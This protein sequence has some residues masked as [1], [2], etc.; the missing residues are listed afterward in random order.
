LRSL[1]FTFAVHGSFTD[2]GYILQFYTVPHHTFTCV[3]TTLPVTLHVGSAVSTLLLRYTRGYTRTPARLFVTHTH[4]FAVTPHI[5]FC[6]LPHTFTHCVTLLVAH[7]VC[8]YTFLLVYCTRAAVHL[9]DFVTV[10]FVLHVS[11][12]VHVWLDT[13]YVDCT[14]FSARYTI[15]RLRTRSR[16]HCLRCGCCYVYGSTTP[17]VTTHHH[18]TR[19]AF[20]FRFLHLTPFVTW[21]GYVHVLRTLRI[22]R[23]RFLPVWLFTLFMVGL[24]AVVYV[25]GSRSHTTLRTRCCTPFTRFTRTVHCVAFTHLS[26]LPHGYAFPGLPHLHTAVVFTFT[27]LFTVTYWLRTYFAPRV[28]ATAYAFYRLPRS[29]L[30]VART[31]THSILPVDYTYGSRIFTRCCYTLLPY[32]CT[33]LPVRFV[34]RILPFCSY[35]FTAHGYHLVTVPARF[36]GCVL[37]QV[38]G[39]VVFTFTVPHCH[40]L[41]LVWLP[42]LRCTPRVSYV[43]APF[44]HC[45][46]FGFVVYSH[47]LPR[48]VCILR[49]APTVTVSARFVTHFGLR[50]VRRTLRSRR[51]L[52]T[53]FTV[54]WFAIL[55]YT[56]AAVPRLFTFTALGWLRP[57]HTRGYVHSTTV[58]HL[59]LVCAHHLHT[60][61]HILLHAHSHTFFLHVHAHSSRT[62]ALRVHTPHTLHLHATPFTVLR[63]LH[64]LLLHGCSRFTVHVHAFYI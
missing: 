47:R 57:D 61:P 26:G 22:L 5:W 28:F 7:S 3:W 35:W 30:P 4:T 12:A 38:T 14:Q 15:L 6:T 45:A 34:L 27:R 60:L 8:G 63:I 2:F 17:L 48:F 40:V 25:Y 18:T 29:W 49:S 59:R 46:H 62:H 43:C 10:R 20:Y 51:S 33:R 41:V 23:T 24:V 1:L 16:L 44:A 19:Y 52:H 53:R 64:L 31:F 58:H 21:F 36:T 42:R 39:C 50:L 55:H 37:L 9:P 11:Y 56:H 54:A 32:C 13:F